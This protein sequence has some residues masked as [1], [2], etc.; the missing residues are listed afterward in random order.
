MSQPQNFSNH[1]KFDP[2]FHFFLAPLSLIFVFF[3]I[4]QVIRV[5]DMEHAG[6]LLVAV[7]AAVAVLKMRLYSL[8]VQDRLICLEERLRVGE[9]APS[10]LQ[11]RIGELTTEQLIGLRF[12]S[13]AELPGLAKKALDD[14]LDRKQVKQ[15]VK[16]WRPDFFR[17]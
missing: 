7:W 15:A 9:L 4:Y 8:K 3:T 6:H 5:P 1:A 17:V 12:A 16:D 11:P 13:D 10:S 2:P 14:K